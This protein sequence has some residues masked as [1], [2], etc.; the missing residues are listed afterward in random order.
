LLKRAGKEATMKT[1]SMLFLLSSLTFGCA[2]MRLASSGEVAAPQRGDILVQASAAKAVVAGPVAIRAYSEFSGGTLFVADA[3]TGTDRDCQLAAHVS[4]SAPLAAD[5]VQSV[6]VGAGK[7]GCIATS[8][9]R[10]IEML[11]HMQ[12]DAARRVLVARNQ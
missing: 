4:A 12:K 8:G 7:V 5:V 1:L 11:W 6:S 10:H 9:T 2:S 3:V